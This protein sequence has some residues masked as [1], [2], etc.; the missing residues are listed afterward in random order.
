MMLY[1]ISNIQGILTFCHKINILRSEGFKY[2]LKGQRFPGGELSKNLPNYLM[3][4]Q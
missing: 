4:F 1:S 3:V 2:V